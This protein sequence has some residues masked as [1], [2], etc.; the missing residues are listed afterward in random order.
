MNEFYSFVSNSPWISFFLACI[1]SSFVINIYKV[2][3]QFILS[4]VIRQ[5]C[6]V[7]KKTINKD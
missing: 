5:N 6:I 3:C 7:T 2:S 4:L 1:A